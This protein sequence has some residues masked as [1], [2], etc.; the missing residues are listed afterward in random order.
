MLDF[1]MWLS[2]EFKSRAYDFL[3]EWFELA[4][5]RHELKEWY[6]KMCK[7]I[8]EVW[9]TNYSDEATMINIVCTWSIATNQRARLGVDKMKQMDDMQ[10]TNASLIKAWLSF[11]ERMRILSSSIS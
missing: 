6:K 9:N 1:M 11:E 3:L 8:C 7:A 10:I 2:P 5:K 4:G